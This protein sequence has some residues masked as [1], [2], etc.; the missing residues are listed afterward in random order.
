M[1]LR[2]QH[3]GA[4]A[5]LFD[6]GGV[7]DWLGA[8]AHDR[9]PHE[10]DRGHDPRVAEERVGAG[11]LLVAVGRLGLGLDAPGLGQKQRF[12]RVFD[13]RRGREIRLDVDTDRD[14]GADQAVL[15]G[16]RDGDGIF[17]RLRLA[18][19]RGVGLGG[20]P[21]EALEQG[22]DVGLRRAGPSQLEADL[23]RSRIGT[24]ALFSRAPAPFVAQV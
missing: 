1:R 20:D 13:D 11:R 5:D 7:G 9:E 17:A 19:R 2:H 10:A 22:F 15:G 14:V 23:D 4:G 21:F 6:R 8:Q 18:R 3:R 24:L 16:R 12:E